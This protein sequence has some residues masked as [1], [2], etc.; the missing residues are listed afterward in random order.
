MNLE[1]NKSYLIERDWP[2]ATVVVQ[3]FIRYV[4]RGAIDQPRPT[5]ARFEGEDGTSEIGLAVLEEMMAKNKI[6]PVSAVSA[7]ELAKLLLLGKRI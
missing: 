5:A 7:D 1:V 2:K 3:R 6:R 4:A